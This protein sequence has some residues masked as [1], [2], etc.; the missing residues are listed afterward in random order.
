MA[1]AAQSEMRS[2]LVELRPEALTRAPLHELL[3]T[4]AAATA[5]KTGIEVD[6]QLDP[7]PVL[8]PDL[9]LAFYRIAQEALTNV[10][11]HAGARHIEIG[12]RTSANP[13]AD[14][15]GLELTVVDDGCGFDLVDASRG[16]LG[17]SSMRERA[18]GIG[19]SFRLITQP[20]DGT[21]VIVRWAG[22]VRRTGGEAH[23][24][25]QAE[26]S[27]AAPIPALASPGTRIA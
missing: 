5:S 4:L 17:L 6:A 20:G 2:L 25:P 16:R 18:E 26:P 24:E 27:E 9:Q 7:V 22:A 3:R 12:L 15:T 11:K 23:P 21:I 19:G 10:V 14:I 1:D 8:P 13:A